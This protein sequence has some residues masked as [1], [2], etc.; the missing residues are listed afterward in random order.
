V[1]DA[2][3]S[4]YEP[5]ITP[6]QIR[7]RFLGGIKLVFTETKTEITDDLLM[8]FIEDAVS[9]LEQEVGFQI[10]P[11]Q[12]DERQPFDRNLYQS[13]GYMRLRNRPVSSIEA[14][15]VT[16]ANNAQLWQVPLE[17]IDTGYMTRGEIY[18]IPLNIAT[19][20]NSF[21]APAG[22]AAFLAILGQQSWVP[23]FWRVKYTTGYAEGKLPRNVNVLIG[24]QTAILV[25]TELAASNA[26]MGSK[27]ISIDGLSQ[28]SSNP[29]PD[30]YKTKIDQL[31]KRKAMHVGKL[32]NAF[33]L[34]LFSGEV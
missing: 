30:L 29:G 27:S 12:H 25:L 10:F 22:G 33:G 34:K 3:W 4:R 13:M 21:G 31:E 11:T 26:K 2:G 8:D 9:D 20:P 32:K 18:I 16:A 19:A 6:D 15:T 5:L 28:S 1:V 17:W 23:A 24:I 14:L 7:S